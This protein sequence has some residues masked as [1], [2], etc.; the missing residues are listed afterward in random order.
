MVS[1]I[2]QHCC[3]PGRW[4]LWGVLPLM[5]LMLAA[6]SSQPQDKANKSFIKIGVIAFQAFT[7]AKTYG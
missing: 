3:C 6:C 1:N 5:T 4:H 2:T 7:G